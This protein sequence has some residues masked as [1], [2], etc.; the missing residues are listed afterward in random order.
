MPYSLKNTGNIEI[1]RKT[2]EAGVRITVTHIEVT[3]LFTC[4]CQATFKIPRRGSKL[5][6]FPES[7]P[8][9][10]WMKQTAMRVGRFGN[11]EE[12]C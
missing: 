4:K 12:R 8:Q 10:I 3:W 1:Q 9:T 2:S 7:R 11:F 6:V 5:K